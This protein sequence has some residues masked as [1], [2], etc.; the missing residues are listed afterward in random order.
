M[1]KRSFLLRGLL[2]L[3]VLFLAAITVTQLWRVREVHGTVSVDGKPVSG[4]TVRI[5]ATSFKTTTDSKGQFA[6]KGFPSR[7]GVTVTAWMDGYYIN[8]VVAHPWQ[9]ESNIS[10]QPYSTNDNTDYA[11]IAPKVEGRS[12]LRNTAIR[13]GLREAA[14][15]SFKTFF[16]PLAGKFTLGCADC[17]GS[18]I[19][20]QYASSAHSKGTDNI[21]FMTIYKGTDV[22]A[23]RS[24]TTRYGASRDY[25]LFPLRP[26]PGQPYYGP[27]FKLDFPDQAGSCAACHTPAQ[28]I[29]APLNTDVNKIARGAVQGTTCDFCHK[30]MAVRLNP[31]NNLPYENMPG[32]LS[33]QLSRPTGEPQL[34]FGPYDDVDVGPDTFSPLQNQSQLCAACHNASFWGTPVYQSYSEWLNSSY[35]AEGKT[36]QSCHMK[37]DGVTTNFAPARGGQERDPQT[38]FTHGCPGSADED[39]LKHTA[40]LKV[41]ARRQG[42]HIQVDVTVTNE[43][44]GHDIPTDSPLRS[45]MLVVSASGADGKPL[46]YLAGPL[47]PDWAGQGK[48][49]TDYARRPGKGYAKIL[50]ELW[51]EVSPTAAYWRQTRIKEDPRILAR[52][53]D[54]THYDFRTPVGGV[55][56]EARLIFRRAFTE[57]AQQKG[58]DLRDIE[59]ARETT[60]L[61]N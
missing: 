7:F 32:V 23:T 11:W 48:G 43:N 1:K 29:A 6:L 13:V 52:A 26:D 25:G 58:W 36:C 5:K 21:R 22:E 47:L 16:L 34:F 53:S 27:G 19:Y 17:H 12:A 41:S 8:G 2:I 54:V 15:F 24:P 30:L 60:T 40:T 3:A 42:D 49:P 57:L 37:P 39:L 33:L 55:N 4:A 51:T 59:M 61:G 38:I 10:L 31:A 35:P 44:A 50:E 45:M 56:I 9:E 14:N 20:S 46:D 28:A 18:T